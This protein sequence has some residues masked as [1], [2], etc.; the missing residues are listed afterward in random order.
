MLKTLVSCK[1]SEFVMQTVRIKKSVEKWL[2]KTDIMNIRK[3]VPELE[4]IPENVTTEERVKIFK[5]NS[6]RQQNQ[7]TENLSTIFDAVFEEHPQET[8]EILALCCFVEPEHVDDYTM[9]EYMQAFVEI[10]NDSAVTS[11]FSSLVRLGQTN[12]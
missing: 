10:I 2:T 6:E 9:S 8:L 4:T 11:F 7:I 3:K 12:I 5:R 1:P